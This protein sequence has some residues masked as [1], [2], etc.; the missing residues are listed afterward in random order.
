MYGIVKN[1]R[2]IKNKELLANIF[3][4]LVTLII[5]FCIFEVIFRILEPKPTYI[6]QYRS[7][8]TFS[9]FEYDSL[10][11]WKHKSNLNELFY[12][13]D[14]V[15]ELKTNS[16]GLR[17]REHSY[18]KP[19]NVVR[20]QFYG[21]SFTWGSGLN[22]TQRYANIFGERM[23]EYSKKDYEIINFGVQGYG[24]DQEYLL[25][26]NE[27]IKYNPNVVI[28]AYHNDLIDV[29]AKEQ[30]TYPRPFFII[31]NETL[32][33]TNVPV[34]KRL[35]EWDGKFKYEAKDDNFMN[36]VDILLSNSKFY[37][38]MRT[39]LI[40]F[41]F[42][43]VF[44]NKYFGKFKLYSSDTT[45][46]TYERTLKV[47]DKIFLEIKNISDQNNSTLV[48]LLIPDK[49]QVY[50]KGNTLE[51]DH[52]IEFGSRNN[53]T[54]INLLPYLKKF[55]EK[56]KGLY[57]RNDGHFSEKGNEI[58]G[59]LSSELFIKNIGGTYNEQK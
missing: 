51:I 14:T 33:L 16:K 45:P 24:T 27:G 44:L 58:V 18:S 29:A 7:Q 13:P 50:G 4:L 30:F 23:N 20:V 1:M 59:I 31:E 22:E 15:F 25:L 42:V 49:E 17:D 34:P 38:F 12:M 28:I 52:L 48:I 37:V 6:E 46:E 40:S 19:P 3:L 8:S 39:K 32:K 55:G 53:I 56:E 21:D 41:N 57:F 35:I 26:K 43:R 9:F 2:K 11:G 54:V 5:V 47:I 10:L 36:K